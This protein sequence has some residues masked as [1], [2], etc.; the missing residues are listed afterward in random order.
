M[1]FGKTK[2]QR[3]KEYA[4]REQRV[5]DLVVP[6]EVYAWLPVQLENEQIA[7]FEKV[8]RIAHDIKIHGNKSKFR[9]YSNRDNALQDSELLNTNGVY[10]SEVL[11]RLS[12]VV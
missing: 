7:W 11:K 4:E 3:V 6:H 5:L 1:L 2:E 12:K 8:W 9:Y 10:R